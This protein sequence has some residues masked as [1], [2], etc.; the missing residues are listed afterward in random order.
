L[1][2]WADAATKGW[3]VSDL[4]R[5]GARTVV[6]DHVVLRVQQ[7]SGIAFGFFREHLHPEKGRWLV[8][9]KAAMA[10]A[11]VLLLAWRILRPGR[12]GLLVPL[13]LV[14]LL[15]GTLGNLLDRA[16]TKA[17]TDFIDI[18]FAGMRWPAFNLAD[19]FL[20]VGLALCATGL[21]LAIR[22]REGAGRPPPR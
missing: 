16:R 13:G 3:A 17:V 5:R 20:A 21:V 4:A 7:N 22:R 6:D 1:L 15:G 11:L 19:V 2:V 18:H 14:A 9:Y 12:P 8:T 10:A